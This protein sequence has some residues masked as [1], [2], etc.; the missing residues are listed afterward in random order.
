[1]QCAIHG[2]Q[3][4]HR[5]AN[6]SVMKFLHDLV[7]AARRQKDSIDYYDRSA[8]VKTILG[9]TGQHLVC[10][11]IHGVIYTLPSYTITDVAELMYEMKEVMQQDFAK[12]VEEALRQLPSQ[13]PVGS[14]TATLEQLQSFQKQ[15][16]RASS[17][18]ELSRTIKEFCRY[19]R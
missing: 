14:Q 13:T 18:K 4:D 17:S 6:V 8:A 11:L 9:N 7:H 2:T 15:V 5:E 19:F 16:M 3:L 1:V 10:M 12:W